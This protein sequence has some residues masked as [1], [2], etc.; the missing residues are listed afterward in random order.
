[1][2]NS[3]DAGTNGLPPVGVACAS[4]GVILTAAINVWTRVHEQPELRSSE[5]LWEPIVW[6][7]TSAVMTLAL[8]P[9]I[10][11]AAKGT[12]LPG[13]QMPAM[14]LGFASWALAFHI[15]HVA[16]FVG[17][18]SVAYAA[19]GSTYVFGGAAS[20]LYEAPKDFVTFITLGIIMIVASRLRPHR[21]RD[22]PD[23][24]VPRPITIKD[25]SRT[26]IVQPSDIL[27]I[28]AQGN[29]VEY[30]LADGRKPLA[31]KRLVEAID[32]LRPHGFIQTHRSWAV[33]PA[34]VRELRSLGG[35]DHEIVAGGGLV[36]PVSRRF[37]AAVLETIK[38]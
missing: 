18:R 23:V 13:R 36:V 34:H 19:A 12:R 29:Y 17:L 24:E 3:G 33:N 35:G 28:A 11:H 4:G 31:R 32:M 20:W 27:G 30:H 5:R 37:N 38:R 10:W 26:F 2:T 8:L 16:G 22:A 1:M 7:V 9:L 21:R 25:A 14:L 15:L 6:E